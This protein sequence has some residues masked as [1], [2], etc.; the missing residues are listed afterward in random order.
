MQ[1]GWFTVRIGKNG[2]K[3]DIIPQNYGTYQKSVKIHLKIE[4]PITITQVR[5][6]NQNLRLKS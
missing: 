4:R 6:Q 5:Q 3:G 2:E 1:E